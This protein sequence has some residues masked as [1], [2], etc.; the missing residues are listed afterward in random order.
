MAGEA[1]NKLSGGEK[2]RIAIVRAM[3][4]NAPIMI[5]DE[6]TASTD[7]ENEAS[8]QEALLAASKGKTLIVVAHRLYTIKNADKIAYV[9]NGEVKKI[10]THEEL[11]NN[12]EEY[13]NLWNL[14]EDNNN[15]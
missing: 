3:L 10:G 12:Y 6:A 15:D 5:L 4:K 2:Q 7:P 1:G 11:M 14:S 9:D 13:K 8:I